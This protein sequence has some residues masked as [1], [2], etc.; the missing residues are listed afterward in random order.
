MSTVIIFIHIVKKS[1]Y[2]GLRIG[3][4]NGNWIPY[5]ERG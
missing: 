4:N 2:M 3:L 1:N 5:E